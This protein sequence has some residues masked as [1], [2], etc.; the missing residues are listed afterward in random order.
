MIFFLGLILLLILQLRIF[1]LK[2]KLLTLKKLITLIIPLVIFGFKLNN[3]NQIPKYNDLNSEVELKINSDDLNIKNDIYFGTG[4]I[5]KI[6]QKIVFY[7]FLNNP[8]EKKLINDLV[9]TSVLKVKGTLNEVSEA[10]N[11]GVF[12]SKKY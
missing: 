3:L 9:T 8:G 1:L 7:G 2:I 10:S 6:N 11:Y 12:D 5:K 4:Y